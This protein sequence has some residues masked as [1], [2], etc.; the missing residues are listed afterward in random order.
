MSSKKNCGACGKP[1]CKCPPGPKGD[2]G[3]KGD[4]GNPGP[5]GE[6]GPTG[7][8]TSILSKFF[9][10]IAPA[11]GIG[12]SATNYL[13]DDAA[14]AVTV[15]PPSY[16]VP[17]PGHTFTALTVNLQ[18]PPLAGATV[19]VTLMRGIV[20]TGLTIVFNSASPAIQS[21]IGSEP[22]ASEE[23]FDLLVTSSNGMLATPISA[24]LR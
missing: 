23:T 14:N 7:P 16:P 19:I 9:S 17:P 13:A 2:R 24:G 22:Y 5:T 3:P 10:G 20:P 1:E 18:S 4:P 11:A 15:F 6:T 8:S 12:A 21:V